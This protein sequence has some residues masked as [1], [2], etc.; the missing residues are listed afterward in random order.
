L[1]TLQIFGFSFVFHF[2]WGTTVP[3]YKAVMPACRTLFFMLMGEFSDTYSEMSENKPILAPLLVI[4]YL[5]GMT[6]ICMNVVL[7]ILVDGYE[8]IRDTMKAENGTIV[9]QTLW[10]TSLERL[11]SLMQRG[12][13]SMASPKMPA[14]LQLLGQTVLARRRKGVED[15]A[16]FLKEVEMKLQHT[17]EVEDA[18]ERTKLASIDAKTVQ[19]LAQGSSDGASE[20]DVLHA[21]QLKAREA[22][23]RLVIVDE[24]DET[25]PDVKWYDVAR[26]LRM[27]EGG[28]SQAVYVTAAQLAKA[29]RVTSVTE[30]GCV[31]RKSRRK[32]ELNV[33]EQQAELLLCKYE[34]LAQ[35]W[36]DFTE[37]TA[38]EEEMGDMAEMEV[39][40]EISQSHIKLDEP[41][42][43]S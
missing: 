21:A 9:A 36:R 14:S 31:C 26:A 5:I 22:A 15:R 39:M 33:T 34:R 20:Q 2:L 40:E 29:L 35:Q 7:A 41:T 8:D 38:E 12:M 24:W 10:D 27:H 23:Q 37:D 16:S 28:L 30:K 19:Q 6:I 32:K 13:R 3:E 11:S 1:F 4:T 25:M 43:K 17:M 18:V 42:D